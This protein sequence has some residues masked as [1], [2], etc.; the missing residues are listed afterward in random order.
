MPRW[1]VATTP[2]AF[3]PILWLKSVVFPFQSPTKKGFPSED[4]PRQQH[5]F[6]TQ[7]GHVIQSRQPSPKKGLPLHVPARGSPGC[8]SGSPFWSDPTLRLL[9]KLGCGVV[10]GGVGLS[11]SSGL[12]L[13]QNC[14]VVF[15][16]E[17]PWKKFVKAATEARG[18]GKRRRPAGERRAF[19]QGGKLGGG[20]HGFN[21]WNVQWNQVG[22][23]H[24]CCEW[25][26]FL[27]L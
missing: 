19:G 10:G 8:S 7:E 12:I 23:L 5:P 13:E 3:Q 17:L 2:A 26:I 14:D 16:T 21:A 25:P 15:V 27:S 6:E 24:L 1:Q 4:A 22:T 18:L 9:R 11:G 20:L